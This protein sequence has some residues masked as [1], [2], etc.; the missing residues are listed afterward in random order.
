M[1]HGAIIFQKTADA[2]G[3][4]LGRIPRQFRK[5]V[6]S[7]LRSSLKRKRKKKKGRKRQKRRGELRGRR[8]EE[9]VKEEG[10]KKGEFLVKPESF[11]FLSSLS[12][13]TSQSCNEP[14]LVTELMYFDKRLLKYF[15]LGT[16]KNSTALACREALK[17]VIVFPAHRHDGKEK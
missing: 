5:N 11:A 2:H 6:Y 7:R 13:D 8:K 4:V 1:A 12:P 17:G 16:K 9:A 14:L 15:N 10:G 3:P